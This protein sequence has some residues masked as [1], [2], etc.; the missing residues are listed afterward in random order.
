MGDS[1]DANEN[2]KK[3]QDSQMGRWAEPA[4][5]V[6]VPFL[7][8]HTRGEAAFGNVHDQG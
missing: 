2:Y 7:F 3:S 6:R 1:L 5:G 4:I 8:R